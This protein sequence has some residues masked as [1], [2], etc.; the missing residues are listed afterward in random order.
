MGDNCLHV[1]VFRKGHELF[2]SVGYLKLC[3]AR[4]KDCG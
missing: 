1:S 4:D 2:L 3:V